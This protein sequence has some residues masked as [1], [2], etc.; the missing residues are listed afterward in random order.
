MKKYPLTL[1]IVTA[2]LIA[3]LIAACSS[4]PSRESSAEVTRL[5]TP[6]SFH[7]VTEHSG[8][9]TVEVLIPDSSRPVVYEATPAM[10][11]TD[12]TA[13]GWGQSRSI[14]ILDGSRTE[15]D[16]PTIDIAMT[17]EDARQFAALT[18]ANM[19]KSLLIMWG[20][21]PL[22]APRIRE[23]ITTGNV[24]WDVSSNQHDIAERHMREV[25][26]K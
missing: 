13:I 17:T 7:L 14:T 1:V 10:T 16:S 4:H 24:C 6:I 25:S 23:A 21:D 12:V 22:A 20:N 15:H 2:A 3:I 9:G 19:G 26:H 11:I 5:Q 8:S 18:S